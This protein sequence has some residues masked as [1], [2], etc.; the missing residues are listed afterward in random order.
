MV[1]TDGG[2]GNDSIALSAI[3]ERAIYEVYAG[4]AKKQ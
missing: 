4:K 1:E 3:H 2:P